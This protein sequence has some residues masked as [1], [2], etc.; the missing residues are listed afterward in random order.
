[1][2][3]AV[4]MRGVF[5]ECFFQK[6]YWEAAV[7]CWLFEVSKCLVLDRWNSW[8]LVYAGSVSSLTTPP[9]NSAKCFLC[10]VC[11]QS[12]GHTFRLVETGGLWWLSTAGVL[13]VNL[14]RQEGTNKSW[15]HV[16]ALR[17]RQN[18]VCVIFPD[19]ML[20]KNMVSLGLL[21]KCS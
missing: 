4:K 9:K 5:C 13:L 20:C 15:V 12:Q 14:G 21:I 3:F 11:S 17:E 16:A 6:L 8:C 2:A 19:V 18:R 7:P 10:T 1:M